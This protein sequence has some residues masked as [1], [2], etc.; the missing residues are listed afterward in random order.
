MHSIL[1]VISG[2]LKSNAN[3]ISKTIDIKGWI[4]NSDKNIFNQDLKNHELELFISVRR[5]NGVSNIRTFI[6]I[7]L[8]EYEKSKLIKLTDIK[9]FNNPSNENTFKSVESTLIIEFKL[10]IKFEKQIFSPRIFC[11][12]SLIVSEINE[13][14]YTKNSQIKY[15]PFIKIPNINNL[16]TNWYGLSIWMPVKW[17]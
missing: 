11:P 2:L 13:L 10:S 3:I 17:E 8:R 16:K 14:K 1:D 6:I 5:A 15:E 7:Y 12:T 4:N 9:L